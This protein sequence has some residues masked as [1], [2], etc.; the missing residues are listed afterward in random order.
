MLLSA[1]IT[2]QHDNKL[3]WEDRYYAIKQKFSNK[4]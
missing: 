1:N 4:L 2:S 3:V